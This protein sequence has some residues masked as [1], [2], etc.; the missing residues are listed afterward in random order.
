MEGARQEAGAS[1]EIK[2][3]KALC[4]WA[5]SRALGIHHVEAG[6]GNDPQVFSLTLKV[7]TLL[8]VRY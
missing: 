3:R 4:D 1:W 7:G 8:L 5:S 6:G 2:Y